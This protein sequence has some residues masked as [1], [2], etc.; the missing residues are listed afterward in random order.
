[1]PDA[2]DA[3]DLVGR[4]LARDPAAV[5]ALVDRLSPVIERRVAAALWRRTSSRDVRQELA[6]MTQEVFLSLFAADGK[7]LR[8]WAP[9]RGLSLE[10]FVGMLAQHQV[11]SILRNGRTSPWR[12]DP[13]DADQI[14]RLVGQAQGLDAIVGS[15]EHLRALLDGLR[16]SLSPR[17]LELFQRL[18][19]D[20]EPLEV[21]C[22]ATGMTREALYQWRSRLL[23]QV[24]DLSAQIE[25]APLS[26]T[27]SELRK[28]T[29]VPKP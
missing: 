6:D 11:A 28:V 25:A 12:D 16:A 14:D 20:E 8:A 18:I 5:R 29:R 3:A 7:A 26:E 22:A 27:V 10:S 24:R 23:R 2:A 19:V 9:A 17:G 1:M 15:R 13:T 4:A 21:L